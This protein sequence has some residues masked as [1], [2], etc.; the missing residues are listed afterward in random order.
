MNNTAD[1]ATMESGIA[2]SEMSSM[3]VS[4]IPEAIKKNQLEI[5]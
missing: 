5:M 2:L 1:N 4:P 3:L